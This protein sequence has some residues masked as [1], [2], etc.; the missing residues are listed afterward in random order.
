VLSTSRSWPAQSVG[1][2]RNGSGQ[3]CVGGGRGIV[4]PGIG[5]RVWFIGMAGYRLLKNSAEPPLRIESA[6]RKA[7]R[8]GDE[9]RQREDGEAEGQVPKGCPR[10][11]PRGQP[12][13]QSSERLSPSELTPRKRFLAQPEGQHRF[14]PGAALE[15][16]GKAVEALHR[17]LKPCSRPK[18]CVASV[19]IVFQKP[20]NVR[21]RCFTGRGK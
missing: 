5:W 21:L 12:R 1:S 3:P 9:A 15:L 6:I 17:Q 2:W 14:G 19:S 13:S 10:R 20:V 7:A 16:P 8:K 11:V 18:S 4:R